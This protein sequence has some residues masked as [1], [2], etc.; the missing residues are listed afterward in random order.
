[1]QIFTLPA[2][3]TLSRYP[4][5]IFIHPSSPNVLF[6]ESTLPSRI[7]FSLFK[8]SICFAVASS[9]VSPSIFIA[10]IIHPSIYSPIHRPGLGPFTY[11]VFFSLALVHALAALDY[12]AR[13]HLD[14]CSRSPILVLLRFASYPKSLVV[15]NPHCSHPLL[16]YGLPSN[17]QCILVFVPSV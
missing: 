9:I 11:S 8:F 12:S 4:V 7:A 17:R 10:S 2:K 13:F 15:V 14:P 16:F 6:T 1:M 5:S 3:V